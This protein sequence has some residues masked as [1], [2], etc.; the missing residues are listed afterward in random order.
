MTQQRKNADKHKT[1]KTKIKF[2]LKAQIT[3]NQSKDAKKNQESTDSNTCLKTTKQFFSFVFSIKT[4]TNKT[5]AKD[6]RP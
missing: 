3:K 1:K 2:W 4:S 6:K 5:Q